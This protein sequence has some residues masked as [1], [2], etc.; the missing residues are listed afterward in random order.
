MMAFES[1]VG[2]TVEGNVEGNIARVLASERR[3][4]P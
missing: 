4:W 2:K 3:V 1:P